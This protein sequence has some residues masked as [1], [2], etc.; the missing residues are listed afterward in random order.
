MRQ[1]ILVVLLCSLLGTTS[2]C[3]SSSSSK[4]PSVPPKAHSFADLV[5]Q[6]KTG[7]IRIEVSSCNGSAIGTGFLVKPHLV[8]TVE[9]V[10]DGAQSIR[11]IRNSVLLGKATVIGVD[12]DRDL[13]LLRTS[14]A[15]SG[16]DFGFA[17]KAPRLGQ[18]VA[19]IGFPLGL[20][21]T[22]TKGSVSGL[23]RA[24]PIDGLLSATDVTGACCFPAKPRHRDRR[25]PTPT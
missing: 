14:K 16:Y 2:G 25:A 1:A 12:K 20:P 7:V 17:G 21:L 11:L 24:I 19:A 23:G 15:I 22:V 13:A 10:V 6:V 8:A 9:H 18:D 5:Q 3:G 4:S